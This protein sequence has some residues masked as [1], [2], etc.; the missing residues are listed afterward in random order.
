MP[1][2]AP[3]TRSSA[4]ASPAVVPRL[5]TA[6]ALLVEAEQAGAAV[7]GVLELRVAA[8]VVGRGELLAAVVRGRVE[9]LV[10]AQLGHHLLDAAVVGAVGLAG[11]E[12]HGRP[13]AEV[14][15]GRG[16]VER[17]EVP[18]G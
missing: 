16:G 2:L 11:G 17:I 9:R 7:V 6:H 10:A 13:E 14:D 18:A 15:V 5:A 3:V 12:R 4:P 8:A 1:V